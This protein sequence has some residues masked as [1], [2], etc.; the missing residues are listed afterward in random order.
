MQQQRPYV[1][2]I[3]GFDPSSGAGLTADIKTFE[4]L[5]AYGLALCTGLTLQSEEEFVSVK[6]R[7]LEEV[8]SELEFIL[9]KYP[10]KAVKF[11][12]VPSLVW[13]EKFVS[14]IRKKTG[15]LAIVVDPVWK[16]G[17]GFEF[18]DI[19][20]ISKLAHVLKQ[21]TL[22]TPNLEELKKISGGKDVL[23]TAKE[24]SAYTAVL[25][26]GGHSNDRKG[27]DLFFHSG[28]VTEIFPQH[29]T[30]TPKH[31]SGCVLSAAIAASLASTDDP[32][33]ACEEA[34]KYTEK[35]LSSN[36]SLLGYHAA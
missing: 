4:Q 33:K 21:I 18:A 27:T 12:I 22:L 5:K 20:D 7:E 8:E 29:H 31:G 35:F 14:I 24:L 19:T 13:L 36:Q 30:C 3:A 10:V 6:W 15:N 2:S 34:K 1:L 23:Q 28:N 26:K 17:T 11:G 9:E 25:V 16:S 32:L